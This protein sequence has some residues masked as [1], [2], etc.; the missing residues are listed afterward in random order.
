MLAESAQAAGAL[1]GVIDVSAGVPIDETPGEG[2]V[3]ED[4]ELAGGGREGL[5]L[6]DP[7]RQPAVEGAEGGL[8]ADESHGRGPQHGRRPIRRRLGLGAEAPAARHPVVRS[9]GEPRREVVLRGPQTEVGANLGNKLEGAIG[10]DAV[11]LREVLASE[12]MQ[13]GADVEQGFVPVPT[14][15]PRG[16]GGALWQAAPPG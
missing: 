1:A 14:G 12:L 6:A 9:Q 3:D 15:D 11:D 16:A 13:D 8:A 2:A 10:A 4:G 5:G 7:D